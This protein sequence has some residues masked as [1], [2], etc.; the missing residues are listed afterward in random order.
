MTFG[1]LGWIWV[2][3]SQHIPQWTTSFFYAMTGTLG[4]LGVVSVGVGTPT[5]FEL[6][7]QQWLD[8]QEF[9]T[10]VTPTGELQFR[11]NKIDYTG[12]QT[13]GVEIIYLK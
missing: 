8:G 11:T 4:E 13:F 3:T 2:P 12:S 6:I 10:E 1:D 5:P 9:A 7:G